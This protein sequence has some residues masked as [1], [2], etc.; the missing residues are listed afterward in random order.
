M[1]T[2][3]EHRTAVVNGINIHYVTQGQGPPVIM[4]HGWPEFWYAWRKQIPVL[5][6]HFEVIVPDLRD[7]ANAGASDLL[8]MI[9]PVGKLATSTERTRALLLSLIGKL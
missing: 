2:Q 3:W 4:L 8:A 5:A 6:E 9:L 7:L 1:T